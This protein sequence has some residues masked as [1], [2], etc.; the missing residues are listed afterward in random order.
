MV[1]SGAYGPAIIN[2]TTSNNFDDATKVIKAVKHAQSSSK[3]VTD[4]L[5]SI[6]SNIEKMTK[7]GTNEQIGD[8]SILSSIL[9]EVKNTNA[10][11]AKLIEVMANAVSGGNSKLTVNGR[12]IMTTVGGIPQPV[13]NG[14]SPD[15][16]D[17]YRTV[18]R[19]VRGQ[20]L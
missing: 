12:N 2:N 4:L 6:D 1:K 10:Y 11:L 13:T 3:N 8:G 5:S 9:T 7:S 16:V 20:A 18:D 15:T 14:V 19:I 17:F